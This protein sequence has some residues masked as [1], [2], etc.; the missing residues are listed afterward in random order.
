MKR[1]YF[2]EEDVFTKNISIKDDDGQLKCNLKIGITTNDE[3]SPIFHIA[4][5]EWD[6]AIFESKFS[7]ELSFIDLLNGT[8]NYLEGCYSDDM[9]YLAY[10]QLSSVL[11][12]YS[13]LMRLK[14]IQEKNQ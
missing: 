3:G 2:K 4:E 13:N 14:A 5:A 7:H 6:D 1:I 11:Q 9:R 8:I 10:E 12:H